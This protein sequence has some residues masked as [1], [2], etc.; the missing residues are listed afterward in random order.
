MTSKKVTIKK[1]KQ[2]NEITKSVLMDFFDW[3]DGWDKENACNLTDYYIAES[4]CGEEIHFVEEVI[5]E[6][7]KYKQK[8][9]NNA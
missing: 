4:P 8:E 6:Y 9:N 7:I 2:D 1:V 5:E 3:M